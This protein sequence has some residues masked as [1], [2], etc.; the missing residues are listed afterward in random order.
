MDPSFFC[1]CQ[2]GHLWFSYPE[3][4]VA[5]DE[6]PLFGGHLVL[7]RGRLVL[8]LCIHHGRSRL[9]RIAERMD[10]RINASHVDRAVRAHSR[11]RLYRITGL[12]LPMFCAVRM[13]A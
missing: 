5:D 12:E 13:M 7:T 3:L 4:C 9:K 1:R 8:I 10:L 2:P 6:P 11:G